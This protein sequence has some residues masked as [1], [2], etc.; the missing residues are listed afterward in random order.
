MSTNAPLHDIVRSLFAAQPLG[1]L[2]TQGKG[3]PYCNIVAFTPS[4]DLRYL[5]IATPRGTSKYN[6]ILQNPG[7]SLMVDNRSVTSPD[8]KHGIAVNCV[9]RAL[10]VPEH[11]FEACRKLHF[12]R[13]AHLR[14]H[15]DSPDCALVRIDVERYIIARGVRQIE[16]L[17]MI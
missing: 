13:H 10:T 9:G 11:E 6:N 7:V 12:G 4:D 3:Y 1:I 17:S 5:L 14:I 2:A 15:L 8:F 16:T